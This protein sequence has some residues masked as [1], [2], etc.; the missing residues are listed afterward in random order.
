MH[1]FAGQFLISMPKLRGTPFG[2][3]VIYVWSHDEEGTQGLVVNQ[4]HELT[5]IKLLHQ[6]DLPTQVTTDAVVADGGPVEPQRGFIL[7][8]GEVSIDS[9]HDAENGLTISHSREVLELIASKQGPKHFLVALGYAGWGPG[10]L[11]HEIRDSSWLTAP[12]CHDTLFN[13]PFE[14]RLDRTASAIGIDLRFLGTE[15][16]LA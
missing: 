1:S 6:L 9:S 3:C 16:G 14:E 15:A 2:D 10:Q 5:L 13:V 8:T 4:P 12:C 7:H 11:E